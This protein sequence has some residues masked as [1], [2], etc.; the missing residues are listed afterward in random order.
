MNEKWILFDFDGVIVNSRQSLYAAYI[1]FL[2]NFGKKG[3]ISEFDRLDGPNIEEIV[4]LLKDRYDIKENIETLKNYYK[5]NIQLNYEKIKLNEG[6]QE[7]LTNLL[8]KKYHL[9]LVTSADKVLVNNILTKYSLTNLFELF[10]F[11]NDVKKSKPNSEIYQLAIKKANVDVTKII[12]IEDSENG[13]ISAVNVG[14]RCIRVN[15]KERNMF[16]FLENI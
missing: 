5:K 16:H 9:G 6:I 14:I 12:A 11:G 15:P 8:R 3:N 10:V 1:S 4:H 13:Y 7:T 2:E